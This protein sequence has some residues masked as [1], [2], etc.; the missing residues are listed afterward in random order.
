MCC[1]K[2][3][4]YTINGSKKVDNS[5]IQQTIWLYLFKGLSSVDNFIIVSHPKIIYNRVLLIKIILSQFVISAGEG[6]LLYPCKQINELL[7]TNLNE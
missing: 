2:E 6:G 5:I 1:P 3:N 4:L 7:Y